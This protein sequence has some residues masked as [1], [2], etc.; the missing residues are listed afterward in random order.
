MLLE[1]VKGHQKTV[2]VGLGLPG[3]EKEEKLDNLSELSQ[4][5]KTA[6]L[7]VKHQFIQER[8]RIHA[9]YFIG[10]GKVSELSELL[11]ELDAGIVVFDDDL[12]PA[13]IRNLE[14]MLQAKVID[15]STL[16]LDIFAKH[17]RTREA[18]SQVELAQLQYFLPRLTR[19]WTHLSRQVG[20]IGT[21][22]PGETQLETDRRLIRKRIEKLRNDLHQFDKQ[23][24]V[25]RQ[26]RQKL[27]QASLIGYTNVGKSTIMNLLSDADVLV[28]N[29][30]FATLDSIV[31]R[32]QLNDGHEILLSDTVGFIRKLP[33]HL[34][35]SFK[36][37]LDEIS[38][39]DLLLHVVDI[40]HPFFQH[41]IHT[42]IQICEKL[43]VHHKPVLIIFNKMDLLKDQ[44]IL[45]LLRKK[46]PDAIFLSATRNI[47]V[48]SLKQ[49]MIEF[50][51]KNFV[52][53]LL[54]IGVQNQKFIHFIH[55]VSHVLEIDYQDHLVEMTLKCDLDSAEKI[56]SL[57]H[58][59]ESDQ[60]NEK[61]EEVPLK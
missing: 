26:Q 1:E 7:E 44:G 60:N 46:Y 27:Y 41:Q 16:I 49:K 55:S 59:Y 48:E 11:Q 52:K 30:L 51:E 25:R 40:H 12:S 24:K 32:I 28:E 50:I 3:Q 39:A 5:A 37:T 43:Q 21:R 47:G 35:A 23:Q 6:G 56:R 54:R 15:R 20:G 8:A 19:Q 57:Y 58:K 9:A 29:Q 34:I 38:E 14:G 2:L 10:P 42:V 36:S 31:R 33:H 4:L 61:I 17:A 22:G 53:I 18:K 13:Q 45:Q